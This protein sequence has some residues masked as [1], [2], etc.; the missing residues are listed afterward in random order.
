[1]GVGNETPFEWMIREC[2]SLGI[3]PLTK[4][5][6]EREDR[7]IY[8]DLMQRRGRA[9]LPKPKPDFSTYTFD[10]PVWGKY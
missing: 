1:V 4:E 8:G 3:T 5:D 7:R 2:K 9:A 10:A 6:F